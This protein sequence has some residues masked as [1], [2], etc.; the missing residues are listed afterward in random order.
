MTASIILAHPYEKS[1]NHAIFARAKETFIKHKIKV[2]AHDLYIENFNPVM[3]KLELGKKDTTD[4]LVKQYVDEML[5][6]RILVF[7]HPNWWGH[8]PAIMTGYIDRIFRP[9]YAYDFDETNEGEPG[10]GKLIDKIGI[11][12][13]TGNTA[14]TREEEFFHDPLENEWTNCLFGFC[15]VLRSK[16]RL[17]RIIADSSETQRKEWLTEV[18]DI[19]TSSIKD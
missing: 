3:P 1:F 6:S 4:P 15:G 8:P 18:E 19:I 2:Y 9:P 13:N 12:F 14:A 10:I 11:V 17:F 7:I 5:E 16:R